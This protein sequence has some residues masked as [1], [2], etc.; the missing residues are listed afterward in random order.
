MTQ[1]RI[2]ESGLEVDSEIELSHLHGWTQF[3]SRISHVHR[4]GQLPDTDRI[5]PNSRLDTAHLKSWRERSKYNPFTGL[6][7]VGMYE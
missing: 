7:N 6:D 4:A 2:W 3:G 1:S 5:I